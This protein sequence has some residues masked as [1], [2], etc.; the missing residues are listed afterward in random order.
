MIESTRS[1]QRRPKTKK[2]DCLLDCL[3]QAKI[4]IQFNSP[5]T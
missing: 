5:N 2:L 4:L 3:I 1:E